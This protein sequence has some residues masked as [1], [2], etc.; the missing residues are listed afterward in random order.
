MNRIVIVGASA[1]G[2]ATAEALRRMGYGEAI[3][4]VG[5]ENCLPYDRPPLSKQILTGDWDTGRRE[6]R[7]RPGCTR[8]AP[9]PM[10]WRCGPGCCRGVGW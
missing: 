6:A 5:D 9:R 10:P 3:T 4:L 7:G 2:L 8:C 1:G